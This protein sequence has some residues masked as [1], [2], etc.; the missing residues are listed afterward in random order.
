M[1]RSKLYVL[2]LVHRLVCIC[3]FGLFHEPEPKQSDPAE[4]WA[5]MVHHGTS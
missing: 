4:P 3:K 5:R 1:V 2:W